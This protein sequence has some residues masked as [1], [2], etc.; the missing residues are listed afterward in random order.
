MFTRILC[1]VDESPEAIEAVRQ[2]RQ[3]HASTPNCSWWTCRQAAAVHAGWAA[4]AVLDDMRNGE[5][6][7]L[8]VARVAAGETSGNAARPGCA[9][10]LIARLG[11]RGEADLVAVGT[12]DRRRTAG[13]VGGSVA[14][15]V[16]HEAPCSVLIARRAATPTSSHAR[17]SRASTARPPL[18]A[19]ALARR[20]AGRSNADLRVV[21]AAGAK[22]FRS[23]RSANMPR[24]LRLDHRP[25]VECPMAESETPTCSSSAAEACMGWPPS[26]A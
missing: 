1:G 9:V 4:T 3:P 8:A 5:L 16:L 18:E 25:P 7:A 15:Y 6:A 13:I 21:A 23:T 11:A 2:A 14:T 26:G 10:E 20:I 12:H 24:T 22:S 17:S 19:L